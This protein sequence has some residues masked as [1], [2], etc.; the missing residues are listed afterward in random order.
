MAT[1]LKYSVLILLKYSPFMLI[2]LQKFLE[3]SIKK[4]KLMEI[5]FNIFP[6]YSYN[7]K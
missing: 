7:Q 5:F 6:L 3:W 1:Y 4:N 2:A